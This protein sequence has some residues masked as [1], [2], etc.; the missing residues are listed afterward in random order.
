MK[1]SEIFREN[2]ETAPR[3]RRRSRLKMDRL[4][5]VTERMEAAWRAL[6]VEQAWL[7]GEVPPVRIATCKTQKKPPK[8]GG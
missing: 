5:S 2:V 8:S 3:S 6:A 1:P 4:I 7:D